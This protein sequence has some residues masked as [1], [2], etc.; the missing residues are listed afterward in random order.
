MAVIVRWTAFSLS[1]LVVFPSPSATARLSL[2]G[3]A[4][5]RFTRRISLAAS[6]PA[7]P[8]SGIGFS[9]ISSPA[10]SP[11]DRVSSSSL[12]FQRVGAGID[13]VEVSIWEQQLGTEL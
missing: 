7:Y 10:L 3:R 8:E 1:S 13:A 5:S 9:F 11:F 2:P 4:F 6:A 12:C